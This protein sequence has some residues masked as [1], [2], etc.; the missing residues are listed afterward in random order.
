MAIFMDKQAIKLFVIDQTVTSKGQ[1]Y[2]PIL[3]ILI[4]FIKD[5]GT[6]TRRYTDTQKDMTNYMIVAHL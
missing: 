2:G 5:T 6:Q 4:G 3:I 1:N